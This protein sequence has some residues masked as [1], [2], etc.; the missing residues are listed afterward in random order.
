MCLSKL[1]RKGKASFD[2]ATSTAHICPEWTGFLH[3][4]I[5]SLALNILETLTTLPLPSPI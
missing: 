2:E 4:E 3:D 5:M 1:F